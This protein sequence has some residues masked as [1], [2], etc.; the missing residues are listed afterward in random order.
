MDYIRAF[1]VFRIL[2]WSFVFKFFL[3]VFTFWEQGDTF[4]IIKNKHGSSNKRHK[5]GAKSVRNVDRYPP[6]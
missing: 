1:T 6:K 2:F 4:Q 3:G 5:N